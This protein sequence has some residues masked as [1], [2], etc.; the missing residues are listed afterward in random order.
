M[1]A[2]QAK[3]FGAYIRNRREAFGISQT[4]L[5]RLVETRDSTINRLEAGGI[6]APRPD[7]LTRI[8][9]HLDLNLADVFAMVGYAV[10][11]QLPSPMPYLRAKYPA[12]P[13]EA[14]DEIETNLRTVAQRHDVNI[15]N[16]EVSHDSSPAKGVRPTLKSLAEAFGEDFA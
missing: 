6:S 10:P 7:K 4:E 16:Q 2:Q 11:R 8:A 14:I 9:D 5:A 1:T 15:D 3:V 13:Q 12:L